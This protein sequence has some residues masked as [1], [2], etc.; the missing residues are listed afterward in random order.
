MDEIAAKLKAYRDPE[1]GGPVVKEVYQ[2]DRIF[3]GP[4][5]AVGPDLIIGYARGYQGGASALGN[6]PEKT[7]KDN[8]DAWCGDH[9]VATD[10]V[11]GVVYCN[12]KLGVDDPTL[13]DIAPTIMHEFG[14]T[15][16]A[17]MKGRNLFARSAALAS[18]R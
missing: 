1:T 10:L 6:F 2:C 9:C 17:I 13:L 14:L 5:V 3:S 12:K 8:T 4:M 16:P 11:P 7:T 15:P 18:N